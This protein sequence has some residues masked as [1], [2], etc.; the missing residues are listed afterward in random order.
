M[1]VNIRRDVGLL[2]LSTLFLTGCEYQVAEPQWYKE[3]DNPPIPEITAVNPES[4]TGGVN[5]ITISG[6]NFGTPPSENKVY[7]DNVS[8]EV[9]EGTETSLTVRR[10][11]LV[12]DTAMI[13]LASHDALV[14]AKYGPYTVTR[15][16]QYYG[17][18]VE[19]LEISGLAFNANG[20]MFVAQSDVIFRYAPPAER[21]VLDTAS[22]PVTDIA[23]APDGQLVLMADYRNIYKMD[24]VTGEE[25]EWVSLRPGR[26]YVRYGNFDQHGNFYFGGEGID[27][28]YL[29]AGDDSTAGVETGFYPDGEILDVNVHGDFLYVIATDR[30]PGRVFR[31]P[32]H[33]DGSVGAPELILD[34]SNP[35]VGY[36][37]SVL[38]TVEVADDGTIYVG[39]DNTDPVLQLNP[40]GSQTILYKSILP[41]EAREL[42][43][44]AGGYLYML[45]GGEEWN[46]VQIDVG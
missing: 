40:D 42:Q 14:V 9:V 7:F 17:G 16:H 35:P 2:V 29:P 5:T 36:A 30:D 45:I 19:N 18:F 33:A 4:A 28:R 38:Y 21:A 10:P 34:W 12:S 24:P 1:N 43:W 20:I 26:H 44:G 46:V 32:V 13:K 31:H 25:T 39:T 6:E 15:T 8:A 27:L 22:R 23:V 37:E 41:T 3:H 11:N